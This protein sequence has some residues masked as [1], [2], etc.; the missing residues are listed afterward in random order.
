MNVPVRPTPSLEGGGGGGGE[1]DSKTVW[2]ISKDR[3][4]KTDGQFRRCP[5]SE[6]WKG[7]TVWEIDRARDKTHREFR[8][9][10]LSERL[11]R[12]TELL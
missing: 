12:W 5:L 6:R 11:N 4:D 7:W 2:E 3:V 1:K 9:C 8:R 10:P